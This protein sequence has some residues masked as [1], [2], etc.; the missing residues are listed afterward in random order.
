MAGK[1]RSIRFIKPDNTF[2]GPVSIK[3]DAPKSIIFLT[4]DSQRTGE[5][6]CRKS[7]SLISA[8]SFE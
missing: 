4:D 6:T 2:P 5:T 7:V 1:D 8:G 3:Y